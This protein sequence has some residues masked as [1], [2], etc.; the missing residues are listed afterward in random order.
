MGLTLSRAT[1]H[2]YL[3]I[4]TL[5][6]ELGYHPPAG[7]LQQTIDEIGEDSDCLI[8]VA[9]LA[10]KPVG[11]IMVYLAKS[12]VLGHVAVIGNLVVKQAHQ[13]KGIGRQLVLA[14]AAWAKE[15]GSPTLRVGSQIRRQQAHRFY[16]NLNF[17][18]YKTQHWFV[19]EL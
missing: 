19:Y 2:D 6:A 13:G 1:R 17:K 7:K 3:A 4:Q 10:D 18:H 8:L 11:V 14:S 12:L 9:R 5:L 15:H 16:Q